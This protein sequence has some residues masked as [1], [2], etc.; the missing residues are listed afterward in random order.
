MAK[1]TESKFD[2]WWDDHVNVTGHYLPR[3]VIGPDDETT[4]KLG[5][6]IKSSTKKALVKQ[7]LDPR[8][9]KA[10]D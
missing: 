10:E 8:A 5:D 2:S 6:A 1:N 3:R 4:K 9:L 7:A